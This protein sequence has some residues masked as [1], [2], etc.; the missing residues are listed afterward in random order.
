MAAI[1]AFA[2]W[3]FVLLSLIAM[4]FTLGTA[5]TIGSGSRPSRKSVRAPVTLLKPLYL[6][7]PEL[8]NNLRSFF[9]QDHEGPIQFVFGARSWADPALKIVEKLRRN[10]PDADVEVVVSPRLA[11][12]N[13]KVA[14]LINMVA[15]AKHE[16]LILS[17]SDIRVDSNYVR[18]VSAALD[19]PQVGAVSCLYSGRPVGNLWSTLAAMGID[20]HFL[21]NARFGI[22]LGLTEPCFGSTIALR[23]QTLNEIGGFES[24]S[25]VLADDFELGRA[26][27]EKGYRLSIPAQP[28]VEHVCGQKSAGALFRQE[29]RWAK[30]NLMLARSGYTGTLVTYP[31]PLA[32][33][34]ALFQDFS[35]LS[36]MI[37]AAALASRLI[38]ALQSGRLLAL[39][40]NRVWLLPMRDVLS[41]G[42]FVASFFG[43]TVMWR[44]TRY[45][46]GAD[47]ALAQL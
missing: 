28:T 40:A 31:F 35:H 23:R 27:R 17:D 39:S 14:N 41:F 1:H 4:G 42:I 8:E 19:E 11:G 32:L 37:V 46:A 47:G 44:G 34:A 26:I 18:Q 5:A 2:G 7:E 3:V 36:L 24:L 33:L 20:Y 10:H 13:P 30:T 29:L 12:S 25:N 15:H 16:V 45:V 6:A 38:L 43:K 22:T 21:P 9:E